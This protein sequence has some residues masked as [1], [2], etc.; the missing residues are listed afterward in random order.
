MKTISLLVG[1]LTLR[2]ETFKTLRERSDVF[3]RGFLLVILVGLVAGAFSAGTD[4]TTQVLRPPNEK[5]VTQEALRGFENSFNGPEDSRSIIESYLTEGVAMGFELSR[6][7][8]N[9]GAAFRPFTK[10]LRWVG[11]S[12]AFPF[13]SGFLGFLLFTALLVHLASRWLG[14]RA[15]IAQMLGLS[16][17]SLAPHIFDP[18]SSL[19]KLTG[20]LTG[21]GAF[22]PL[23]SL[24][25]FVVFVWGLVIYIKATSIAQELSSARAIG[26]ILIAVG[27]SALLAVLIAA[28]MG[29]VVAGLI[30][31]VIGASR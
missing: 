11:Q 19:L 7:P 22:G 23:E 2:T 20:N 1:A 6:L 28:S 13:S 8:P 30:V 10:L 3:Y 4:L 21:S 9:S 18:L 24:I 25:G 15:G 16:S 12:V 29:A 26:S 17:L 27:L 5:A 31:S 14:G